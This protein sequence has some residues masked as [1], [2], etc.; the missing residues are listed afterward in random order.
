MKRIIA[1]MTAVAGI[2]LG[3]LAVSALAPMV[4]ADD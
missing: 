3:S 2:V 1:A 4:M